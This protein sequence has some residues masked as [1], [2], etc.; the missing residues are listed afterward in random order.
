MTL[1]KER[2]GEIAVLVL[3]D[4]MER[5]GGIRL[6]PKE[7]R[8]ELTN[9]AKKLGILPS[10]MAELAKMFLATTYQKVVAELDSMIDEK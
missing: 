9:G 5:D 10:E 7:I 2:A 6:N 1:S 3:Q 4:K 8:R